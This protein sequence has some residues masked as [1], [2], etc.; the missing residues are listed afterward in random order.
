MGRVLGERTALPGGPERARAGVLDCY[1]AAER[2]RVAAHRAHAGPY[3]VRDFDAL[4][5]HAR[6]QHS[7]SAG[8]GPCGDFDAARGSA[9]AGGARNRLPEAGPGRIYPARV[10]MEGRER[11]TDHAADE[12]DRGELRL[13]AREVHAFAGAFAR[14]AHGVRAVV[15]TGADLS[16]ALHDEL[17]PGVLDGAERPGGPARRAAGAPLAYPLP[18]SWHAGTCGCGDDAAGNDA[19]RHGG[20]RA[21]GG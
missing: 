15:R 2:D 20:G 7:V 1:P 11:R 13:V 8:D 18:G 21:P 6:L 12:A 14:G 17:V 5:P 4:A 19:G 3:G 9:G 10:E 16:R